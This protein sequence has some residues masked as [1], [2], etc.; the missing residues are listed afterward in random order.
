MQEK[1]NLYYA[2]G[3]HN[4]DR[5]AYLDT[6][7]QYLGMFEIL[8]L[9]TLKTKLYLKKKKRIIKKRDVGKKKQMSNV[10]GEYCPKWTLKERTER[11]NTYFSKQVV[12]T[13]QF[14]FLLSTLKTTQVIKVLYRVDKRHLKDN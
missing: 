10:H 3:L 1:K 14:Q 9:E 6:H 11:K 13:F 5:I 2:Q 12:I 7:A 8:T 4:M